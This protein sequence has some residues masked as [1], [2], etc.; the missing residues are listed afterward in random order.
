MGRCKFAKKEPIGEHNYTCIECEDSKEIVF[1][2]DE[3]FEKQVCLCIEGYSKRYD[4]PNS[5]YFSC[6]KD[7]SP[8]SFSTYHDKCLNCTLV[9]GIYGQS[10]KCLLF[11]EPYF[12]NNNYDLDHCD[13]YFDKCV[14]CYYSDDDTKSNLKC[15][16]CQE[17]YFINK[18]GTCELC[19]I[20]Q[21]VGPYCLLCVDYE[22][23]TE[24]IQCQRCTEGYFLTKDNNCV[25]WKMSNMG[26]Q[27]V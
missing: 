5:Y 17:G 21:K 23:I 1:G 4:Y 24:S 16:K 27:I 25:F 11:E 14:R 7:K 18:N 10:E 26:V 13:N 22:N 6:V 3:Y 9:K 8:C 15:D 2:Y 19:Y 20:N 12:L